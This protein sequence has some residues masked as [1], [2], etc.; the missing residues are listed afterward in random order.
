MA[1]SQSYDDL[2]REYLA[3]GPVHYSGEIEKL[4]AI[5]M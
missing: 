4:L 2:R 3:T 5:G 1:G